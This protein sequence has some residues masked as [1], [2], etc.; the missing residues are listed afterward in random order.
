MHFSIEFSSLSFTEFT[1]LKE[2]FVFNALKL[3]PDSTTFGENV[4]TDVT[5]ENMGCF[6]FEYHDDKV[7]V[8]S[9]IIL[10]GGEKVLYYS[11]SIASEQTVQ[12]L[13]R[14]NITKFCLHEQGHFCLHASAMC[15]D[16]KVILFVGQKG[17]GKSTLATYFHLKGH[18]V[19]CDDYAVL[20]HEDNCF[21]ASQGET[22]L[23][24]NPDIVSALAIPETNI[25]RVFELPSGWN[26]GVLGE[27]ITQKYYFTQGD[28]KTDDLPREVAA[29]F[30]INQRVA[31]P[32]E[33]IT[34]QKKSEALSVLM[35]E[36][37]LPGLNSKEYLKIYFQ[38][39]MTFLKT[40]P[41][42]AIHSPDD[43]TRIHEV[44][45]SIL[46]TINITLNE[47]SIR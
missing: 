26:K 20:H 28:N 45:N 36:I 42:Y 30:F 4:Y 23:K 9:F 5:P 11:T 38:S 47:T 6:L 3:S 2:K 25:K 40:V 46:E 8:A 44:Y 39:V 16:D 13:L 32:A 33:L 15:I 31:E 21:L 22:S 14:G 29:I 34:T 19:W 17:A 24:I 27:T 1:D 10:P 18:G 43:I 35:D 12:S 37:L 7:P 41:S